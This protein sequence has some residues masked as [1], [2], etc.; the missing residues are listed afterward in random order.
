MFGPG[1]GRRGERGRR[2]RHP[3]GERDAA[4][5]GGRRDLLAVVV[6]AAI[7]CDGASVGS[8]TSA[9]R[10]RRGGRGCRHAARRAWG[11]RRGRAGSGPGRAEGPGRARLG[12][13]EERDD[14]RGGGGASVVDVSFASRG[15]DPGG[16]DPGTGAARSVSGVATG[17]RAGFSAWRGVSS[18]RA[19][20]PLGRRRGL[21]APRGGEGRARRPRGTPWRSPSSRRDRPRSR[22]PKPRRGARGRTDPRRGRAAGRQNDRGEAERVRRETRGARSRGGEAGRG[23]RRP[24]FSTCQGCRCRGASEI[25]RARAPRRSSGQRAPRAAPKLRKG[26]GRGRREIEKTRS[27]HRARYAR[28]APRPDVERAASEASRFLS[29]FLMW[30]LPRRTCGH[31]PRAGAESPGTRARLFGSMPRDVRRF[32]SVAG[33]VETARV[34]RRGA[35]SSARPR[36]ERETSANA[37]STAIDR[38]R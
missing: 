15:S 11:G 32:E 24:R 9:R 25:F 10:R 7:G 35:R 20:P 14:S 28:R 36:R 5:D 37:I 34:R 26:E 31:R 21:G 33:G 38:S 17:R 13:A 23:G 2:E 27:R 19:T 16:P 3:G 6:G 1:A 12:T 22:G 29:C 30:S 4:P 18:G 8:R